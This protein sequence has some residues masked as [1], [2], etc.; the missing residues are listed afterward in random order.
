MEQHLG[1][2]NALQGDA[3]TL[4]FDLEGLRL[5][6]FR[7]VRTGFAQQRQGYKRAAP[8]PNQ[9]RRIRGIHVFSAFPVNGQNKII[10]QYARLRRWRAED[11]HE[12]HELAF[13]VLLDGN[14]D[15]LE[16]TLGLFTQRLQFFRGNVGAV[17]VQRAHHAAK[18]ALH[19]FLDVNITHIFPQ[20]DIDDIA[21]GLYFPVNFNPLLLRV[22]PQDKTVGERQHH[23]GAEAKNNKKLTLTVFTRHEQDSP[24]ENGARGRGTRKPLSNAIYRCFH[25][26]PRD[27][28]LLAPTLKNAG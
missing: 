13:F 1:F 25:R 26:P 17:P 16:F 18:S 11:G 15:A 2:F 23:H 21:D 14:P 28:F 27:G 12:N 10:G 4:H 22:Y 3:R 8:A 7:P 6:A 19:H 9:V 5:G 24:T 20:Y